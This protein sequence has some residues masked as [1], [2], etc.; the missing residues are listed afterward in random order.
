MEYLK[1]QT[2][3]LQQ[4]L[5]SKQQAL[6]PLPPSSAVCPSPKYSL[7]ISPTPASI[8]SQI[9]QQVGLL[10]DSQCYPKPTLSETAASPPPHP[11]SPEL[12]PTSEDDDLDHLKLLFDEPPQNQ[13]LIPQSHIDYLSA[14]VSKQGGILDYEKLKNACLEH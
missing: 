9:S 11:L 13:L 1:H 10:P 2:E 7:P 14:Q 8:A 3:A 4:I 12:K 6:E 5:L